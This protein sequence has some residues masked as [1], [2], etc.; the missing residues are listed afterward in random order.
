MRAYSKISTEALLNF[1]ENYDVR[2]LQ[3]HCNCELQ[4]L[5]KNIAGCFCC[6]VDVLNDFKRK[7]FVNE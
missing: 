4:Q 6:C 1:G 2:T 5:L 7:T 3:S